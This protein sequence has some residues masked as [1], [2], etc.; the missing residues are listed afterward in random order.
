[1]EQSDRLEEPWRYIQGTQTQTQSQPEKRDVAK[2]MDY[3]S[4]TD[5]ELEQLAA[6]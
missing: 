5:G 3:W 4:M 1:L 2:Q 6:K